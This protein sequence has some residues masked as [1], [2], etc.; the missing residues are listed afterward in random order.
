MAASL[1][2][3]ENKGRGIPWRFMRRNPAF[4]PGEYKYPLTFTG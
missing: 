2:W 4:V 1:A 3:M